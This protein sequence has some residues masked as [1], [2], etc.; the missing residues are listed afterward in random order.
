MKQLSAIVLLLSLTAVAHADPCITAL[1]IQREPV[2]T[3]FGSH[4]VEVTPT[5]GQCA[6]EASFNSKFNDLQNQIKELRDGVSMAMAAG[7]LNLGGAAAAAGPGKLAAG[8]GVGGYKQS[9]SLSG[10]IAYAISKRLSFSGGVSTTPTSRTPNIGY[11]AG[12]TL[13]LN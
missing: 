1:D 3:P 5:T 13:I 8:F 2:N 9:V 4:V 10:G 12:A 7:Q 6:S 11:F